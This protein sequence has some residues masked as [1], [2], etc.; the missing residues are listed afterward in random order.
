[1]HQVALQVLLKDLNFK[2]INELDM[3]YEYKYKKNDLNICIL[4]S[5][6]LERIAVYIFL[7]EILHPYLMW[8]QI[9]VLILIDFQI[10]LSMHP[11]LEGASGYPLM[12]D[13]YDIKDKLSI[14]KKI[15]IFIK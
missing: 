14:V 8:T 6:I 4:K 13:N 15:K 10:A 9:I 7:S 1:M 5:G 12:F 3:N 11:L 2:N